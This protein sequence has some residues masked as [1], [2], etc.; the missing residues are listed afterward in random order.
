MAKRHVANE[1][2]PSEAPANADLHAIEVMLKRAVNRVA[3]DE[4]LPQLHRS[5]RDAALLR[6]YAPSRR[7]TMI[8]PV[9]QA[10][11][12]DEEPDVVLGVVS[13]QAPPLLVG[14]IPLGK[15]CTLRER[16]QGQTGENP[17]IGRLKGQRAAVR[18][19]RPYEIAAPTIQVSNRGQR[20]VRWLKLR[21]P[22]EIR[23]R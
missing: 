22:L 15:R 20:L 17:R 1:G 21:R 6:S 16:H 23:E 13:A 4:A 18:G 2:V 8:E 10:A 14:D 12:E 19:A 7:P 3:I 11:A 5:L 9:R